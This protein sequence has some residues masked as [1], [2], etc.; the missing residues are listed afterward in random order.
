MTDM[1]HWKWYG[2]K[3]LQV[4]PYMPGTPVYADGMLPALYFK[5]KEEGKIE[6]TFCG[7]TKNLDSFISFFDR[8]KTLQVLCLVDEGDKLIPAGFSWVDNPRGKDGYRVATCGE[9]FFNAPAKTSAARGLARLALA[10]AFYALKIDVIHGLQ[11]ID[12]I[13]ARNFSMRLG[14]R[15]V[16]IVPKYHAIDGELIDGRVLMLTKEEYMPGFMKWKEKQEAVS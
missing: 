2:T 6:Q 1:E 9:A 13:P 11:V 14:F 8:L 10:Y 12:N 3:G 4:V 7:D 5:L 15:E 16:A